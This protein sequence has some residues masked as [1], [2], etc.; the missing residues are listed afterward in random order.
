MVFDPYELDAVIDGKMRLTEKQRQLLIEESLRYEEC[1]ASK[2]ELETYTDQELAHDYRF[3][4]Y[5]YAMD[6]I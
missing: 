5:Q 6:Q 2:E 4:M 1:T 3:W